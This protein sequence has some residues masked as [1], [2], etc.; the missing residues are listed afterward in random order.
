[1]SEYIYQGGCH[2]GSVRFKFNLDFSLEETEILRCYC[3]LCEKLGY[4]HIIVPKPDFELCNDWEK[5]ECYQFNTKIAMHYFCKTCGVKSF[6]QPRSHPDCWSINAR[7]IDDIE[8][9]Q[10]T[11]KDFNGKK[12]SENISTIR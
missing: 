10:L 7:C 11:I 2:C 3:S 4:L 8:N 12:W 1:M 5:L 6:Y 9:C